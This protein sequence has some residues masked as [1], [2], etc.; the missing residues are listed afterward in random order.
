MAEG[1]VA[2]NEARACRRASHQPSEQACALEQ[3][4]GGRGGGGGGK[5]VEATEMLG[6]VGKGC[7][8]NMLL[9]K[10]KKQSPLNIL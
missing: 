3:V 4:R 9:K 8:R 1:H 10:N 6:H 2:P 5:L 7:R